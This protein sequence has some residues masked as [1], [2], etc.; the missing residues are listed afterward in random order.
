[1]CDKTRLLAMALYNY[2]SAAIHPLIHLESV[3]PDVRMWNCSGC[4]LSTIC[5]PPVQC[6]S[7]NLPGPL[8][9]CVETRVTPPPLHPPS[10]SSSSFR[11]KE[12][13][14]TILLPPSYP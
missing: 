5:P 6:F 2:S 8:H 12:R 7:Q 14:P 3:I 4:A 1:M 10:P 9:D 13:T 11:K